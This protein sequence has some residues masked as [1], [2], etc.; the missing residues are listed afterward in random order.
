MRK[1]I[2]KGG[3]VGSEGGTVL[4]D[5]GYKDPCRITL[6]K[7]QAY[8]AITHGVHGSMVYAAFCGE[9]EYQLAY[10]RLELALQSFMDKGHCLGREVGVL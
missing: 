5:E 1:D 8:Y 10:E 4:L 9:K 7:C 3:N 6:E 2:C